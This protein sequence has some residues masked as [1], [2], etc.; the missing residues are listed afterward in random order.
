MTSIPARELVGEEL[1]GCEFAE[2][3]RQL[4]RHAR[5]LLRDGGYDHLTINRL[6]QRSG[7]ARM[8]LYRHFGNRQDVVLKLA[9]QSTSRRA[10]LIERAAMFRGISRE[11]IAAVAD[12]LRHVMPHHMRHELLVFE[13]GIRDKA[14]PELLHLLQSHEDRIVSTVIGLIRDAVVAGDL[15]LPVDLPPEKLGLAFIHL[16]TGAQLLMRRAY[17]YGRYSAEDSRSVL[18]DF[19]VDLLDGLGWRPLYSEHDYPAAVRRMWKELFP[20]EL[21]KFDIRIREE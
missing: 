4:L 14:S 17:S 9:I 5:A 6:S 8:T 10:D 13:D 2:R 15:T 16:E 20:E 1:S 18:H 11:R 12:V 21:A 3:E 19:G 7:L